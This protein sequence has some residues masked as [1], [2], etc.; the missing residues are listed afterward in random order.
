MTDLSA[1]GLLLILVLWAGTALSAPLGTAASEWGSLR[2]LRA[3]AAARFQ[4]WKWEK[5]QGESL[6]SGNFRV[7]RIIG[8]LVRGLGRGERCGAGCGLFAT[9]PQ[10][11]FSGWVSCSPMPR[12]LDSVA[13]RWPR[14]PSEPTSS[15]SDI[16]VL[17]MP[18]V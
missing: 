16:L 8:V 3:G 17:R 18:E 12:L 7:C 1:L 2:S 15:F 4:G 13:S 10:L 5:S 6:I 9:A 11:R 14:F